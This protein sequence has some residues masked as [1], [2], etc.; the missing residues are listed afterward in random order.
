MAFETVRLSHGNGSQTPIIEYKDQQGK[1]IIKTKRE[2]I[3]G[4]DLG[5]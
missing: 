2:E 5:L 3:L 4:I 1:P